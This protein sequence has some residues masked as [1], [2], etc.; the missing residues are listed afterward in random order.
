MKQATEDQMM[1]MQAHLDSMTNYTYVSRSQKDV[2]GQNM[3]LTTK[4]KIGIKKEIED[5]KAWFE[6]G[7]ENYIKNITMQHHEDEL[8]LII[9]KNFI[10]N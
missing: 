3:K 5:I 4:M 6:R 10:Y 8:R 7:D 9:A 2:Y 1:I